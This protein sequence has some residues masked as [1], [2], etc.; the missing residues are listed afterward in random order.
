MKQSTCCK[1]EY[2]TFKHNEHEYIGCKECFNPCTLED[3]PVYTITLQSDPTPITWIEETNAVPTTSVNPEEYVNRGW[4]Y[5][6]KEWKEIPVHTDEYKTQDKYNTIRN[7]M[8]YWEN[9]SVH[10]EGWEKR[11]DKLVN[12]KMEFYPDIF[13]CSSTEMKDFIKSERK[14]WEKELVE[15]IENM[16]SLNLYI[17]RHEVIK[18][19]QEK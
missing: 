14:L 15:K 9:T 13:Q 3:I 12:D 10:T 16:P 4:K 1:K 19:I 17:D 11:F 18:L 5:D 8:E 6:G 2:F 7:I